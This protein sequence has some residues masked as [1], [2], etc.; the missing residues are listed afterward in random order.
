MVISSYFFTDLLGMGRVGFFGHSCVRG[1]VCDL[2]NLPFLPFLQWRFTFSHFVVEPGQE[3][4][5]TVHHL[6]KPI[7][8]GD[9]NHQSRNFPV[10][11]K[12]AVPSP[13]LHHM[14]LQK[15]PTSGPDISL[16]AQLDNGCHCQHVVP[17]EQTDARDGESFCMWPQPL[18]PEDRA[19]SLLAQTVDIGPRPQ[20]FYGNWSSFLSREACSYLER[21]RKTS[22]FW[23]SCNLASSLVP[24][25]ITLFFTFTPH[26]ACIYLYHPMYDTI[27]SPTNLSCL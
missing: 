26:P 27:S 10:P 20:K 15:K 25:S 12:S 3:Y 11:G 1:M 7:P 16:P 21:I 22:P 4:E 14:A 2:S 6:P 13:S 9:P 17:T 8:D 5:V 18:L 19:R 24:A 23:K